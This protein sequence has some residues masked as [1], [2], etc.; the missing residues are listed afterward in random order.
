MVESAHDLGGEGVEGEGPGAAGALA[1]DGVQS[2]V[3]EQHLAD[4][5]CGRVLGKDSVYI[6]LHSA[7]PFPHIY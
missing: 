2:R 3:T 4:C 7:Q 6:L 5:L 1:V